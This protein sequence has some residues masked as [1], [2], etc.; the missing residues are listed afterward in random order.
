MEP[1]R[2]GLEGGGLACGSLALERLLEIESLALI[3][4]REPMGLGLVPNDCRVIV[5]RRAPVASGARLGPTGVV[6]RNCVVEAQ[7]L[8][9][10]T[11]RLQ[12]RCAG[13]LAR[14]AR[15]HPAGIERPEPAHHRPQLEPLER[16]A[17][18]ARRRPAVGALEGS[19]AIWHPRGPK[20]VTHGEDFLVVEVPR[21]GGAEHGERRIACEG[22][23]RTSELKPEGAPDRDDARPVAPQPHRKLQ[24]YAGGAREAGEV[25]AGGV[26]R[27]GLRRA[28][29]RVHGVDVGLGRPIAERV[30]GA[31]HDPAK[32]ARRLLEQLLREER[33]PAR[34]EHEQ[35]GPGASG[36]VP[37][38]QVQR[39]RLRRVARRGDAFFQTAGGSLRDDS[40]N[41]RDCDA[42]D[43]RDAPAATCLVSA[44]Q[45]SRL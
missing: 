35:Q 40:G 3:A 39:V 11:L 14:D 13:E 44:Q 25:E 41:G 18:Q 2:D 38:R 9:G 6:A 29:H 28:E 34:V 15:S 32:P 36:G 26:D 30:V 45:R 8:R 43:Q 27:E 10:M 1:A 12:F 17:A 42:P 5:Q 7:R 23:F 19:D 31:H 37:G 20:P 33:A 16:V 24:R 4:L 21:A 22:G